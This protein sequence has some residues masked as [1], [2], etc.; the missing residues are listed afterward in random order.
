[1]GEAG[2]RE[3][4]VPVVGMTCAA[5]V[6]RVEKAIAKTAGVSGVTVNLVTGRAHVEGAAGLDVE[7]VRA[8]VARAGYDS[9]AETGER[10]DPSERE[11]R[12]AVWRA[13]VGAALAAPV[14][15]L[16]MSHGPLAHEVWSR[17]TQAVLSTVVVLGPGWPF[18][19]GAAGALRQRTADMNVL[20]ALG[21]LAAMVSSAWAVSRDG[22]DQEHA[23]IYFESAAAIVAL[24]L[25]GRALEARAQ[26]GTTRRLRELAE[27]APKTARVRR[28]GEARELSVTHL[29]VGDL[30][31]VQPGE[32]LAVD[33]V[34]TEGKASLDE[35][36]LTGE[37]VPVPRG[38]GEQVAAG[39][40]AFGGSLTVRATA[41]GART[42][43]A[44]VLA[45]VTAAQTEK[46]G[47]ARLA[48][49]VSA[50]FA[51]VV[52]ALAALTLGGWIAAGV[53]VSTAASRAIAV[54]VVACPCAL[55]LAIPTVMAVGTG[56]A[57]RR[58][59][60]LRG[61]AA[62]ERASRVD[63]VVVDKTGTL[64]EGHPSVTAVEALTGADEAEVLRF[65]AALEQRS[66]HPLAAAIVREARS[67]KI[68]L[69][70]D[71]EIEA[72]AGAGVRGVVDGAPVLVGSEAWLLAEGVT[73]GPVRARGAASVVCVARG[74]ALFGVIELSD[75]VRPDARET[76]ARLRDRGATVWMATGDRDE[77]AREVARAVGIEHVVSGARPEDKT[78]LV[79]RLV[80]EGHRVAMVGDGVNDGPALAK[81]TLG[82]AIG[83][84]TDAARA[85]ADVTLLDP[86]LAGVVSALR[87]AEAT[88][89][90][91]KRSLFWAFAYNVVALPVAAG[92]LVPFGGP[93]LTPMIASLAMST[94]SVS[95]VVASLVFGAWLD[96]TLRRD[97]SRSR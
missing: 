79:T 32:A 43:A 16:G 51:V 27:L 69:P 11:A 37:S 78:A 17:W 23:P 52:V 35:S 47:L 12:V 93:E 14:V 97:H 8:S 20:V 60:L 96:A 31:L 36:T 33:G 59:I 3:L 42:T 82:I 77:V 39:T 80:D 50:V 2:P 7:A 83:S 61:G 64:T 86:R 4:D 30:V 71:V 29:V 57:A 76:V 62:L 28:G 67:H 89:T 18:L 72:V 85:A 58:G 54:L 6:R 56:V 63:A 66:E 46:I 94:S 55:G 15:F 74:G 53:G 10:V 1:M 34:I 65:A 68:E 13:V 9:P 26:R 44:R 81:A 21:A 49:G 22:G 95:V 84:G 75:E 25:V 92:L 48:D 19:R 73:G 5:C 88:H 41:V 45:A 40:V 87:V 91:M 70:S 24:V 90:A 38:P